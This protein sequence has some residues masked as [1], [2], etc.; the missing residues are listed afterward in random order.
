MT[1][2]EPADAGQPAEL[3]PSLSARQ[4]D[5]LAF[6]HAWPMHAGAKE[7]AIRLQFGLSVVRYYQVLNALIDSPAAIAHDPIITRRLRRVRDTRVSARAARAQGLR[8]II[9][10][11]EDDQNG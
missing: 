10:D 2:L 9:A 4:R 11:R 6:E 1:N 3:A 5:I 8:A 7:E